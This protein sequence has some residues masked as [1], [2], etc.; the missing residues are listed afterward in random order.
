[1]LAPEIERRGIRVIDGGFGT[2]APSKTWVGRRT[3][4]VGYTL[5]VVPWIGRTLNAE[6]ADIAHFY[7]PNAYGYGMFACLLMRRSAKRVMSRLSLNFYKGQHKILSWIERSLLHRNLD[8]AIGNSKLILEE[9]AVEGVPR[10][11][12]RL[13]YN[14]IDPAPF[15]RREESRADA[16][17]ALGIE[18]DAF[19]IV[20]VGNLHEY[21][22]HRDLIEACS[23]VC[24]R[25]PSEWRL[26]I[27]GRDEQGNRAVY[28][29]LIE[30]LGLAEHVTLLG[31]C[32]EV[33]ELLLAADVFVQ[34]SHH[35][36][37]PNAIIEAM[38]ASLPVIATRVGGIPEA[39]REARGT[40]DAAE[41]TG[42][43]VS[44]HDPEALADALLQ[45][46]EDPSRRASMGESAC[47]RVVAEFSLEQSVGGYETIYRE[48]M[49]QP[50]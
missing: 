24:E 26:M 32:S 13:L 10:D 14:G 30:Q 38:A 44:P 5:R 23:A 3:R 29:R 47:R 41:A 1:V 42:W 27:A 34:P 28:E 43:L 37:L 33:P 46:V 6:N 31:E 16:R 49:A 17:V 45:A 25:L 20:A 18:R 48:L 39:V 7:L 35:E 40:D 9:L 36:G 15:A 12:V 8:I 19:V 11:R 4:T 2:P 22:G 21:K 50:G